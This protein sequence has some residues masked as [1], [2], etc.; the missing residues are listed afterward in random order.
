MVQ[1]KAPQSQD[2]LSRIGASRASLGAQAAVQAA[3]ELLRI[4]EDFVPGPELCVADHFPGK[5]L[6][7]ERTNGRTRATV[8]TFKGGVHPEAFQFISKL[9]VNQ[10]HCSSFPDRT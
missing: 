5:M 10:S 9:R 4:L 7:D 2:Q 8:E 3:P 6:V 1:D